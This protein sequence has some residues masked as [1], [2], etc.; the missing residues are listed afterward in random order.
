MRGGDGGKGCERQAAGRSPG[1]GLRTSVT[2][3]PL[4]G[5]LTLLG[6]DLYMRKKIHN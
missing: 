6:A 3:A 4:L 5:A 1:A 2:C